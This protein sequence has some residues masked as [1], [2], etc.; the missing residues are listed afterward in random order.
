VAPTADDES[1]TPAR[2]LREVIAVMAKL[3]TIAFGG[4]AVH[5]AMLRDEAVRRRHWLDD[6][7]FLDLFGAVSILPGPSSTQLA[8]VLSRRRAGW[9]GLVLGGACFIAPAMVI[10][11]VLAWAYTRYGTTPAGG[12]LLYGV[13]PIVVAVVAVALWQLARTALKRSWYV[14]V[15]LVAVAA[16]FAGVNV[17][18]PL[19]AGGLGV[20][21]V[22]QGRRMRPGD[23][24]GWLPPI[25][26]IPLASAAVVTAAGRVRP[27]LVAVLAE[28]AKLGV[29]VFGSGYVLLAFLRADLVTH[30]HW[31][32]E[33]QVLDA[34]A[35]GQITPGPVFTTATFVGYL[36]GGVPAALVD[37]AGIF[38]P[39]F[40]M[41]GVLER[42][43]GRIRR[44]PVLGAALDGITV[45]AL[46]LMAAVT[47]DLGHAAIRDALT[48][49]LAAAALAVLL[50]WRPNALWLVAAGAAVGV[51]HSV[52]F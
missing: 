11:L 48:A 50:R 5:V 13:E 3:G 15:G 4:P 9:P 43:V 49:V 23:R 32:T 33:R 26:A 51:G 30:S 1:L 22:E 36:L 47:I 35:A 28:F 42:H 12:G 40:V 17:L 25:P 8:I 18:L 46:G 39:S 38:V 29:I 37:T 34:V 10:V 27:G 19:L 31:L 52:L 16:Y 45:A 14:L 7:E 24:H 20:A 21:G 44:S 6:Q 41:V 2:R